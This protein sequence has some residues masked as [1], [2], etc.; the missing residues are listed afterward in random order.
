MIPFHFNVIVYPIQVTYRQMKSYDESLSIFFSVGLWSH[1]R[2]VI[3]M[4]GILAFFIFSCK[5]YIYRKKDVTKKNVFIKF[6]HANVYIKWFLGLCFSG[7]VI[8]TFLVM[9]NWLW[10][11]KIAHSGTYWQSDKHLCYALKKHY[12]FSHAKI[13]IVCCCFKS[14]FRYLAFKWWIVWRCQRILYLSY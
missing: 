6:W 4:N 12:N 5:E 7:K 9:R 2:S 8:G 3:N 1:Q 10:M 13:W 14:R 11:E